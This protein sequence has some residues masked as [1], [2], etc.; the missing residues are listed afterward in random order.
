MVSHLDFERLREAVSGHAAAFRITTRLQPAGGPGA[1]V[2]PPT[3]MGGV[4]AWERRRIGNESV[5]TVL[6]D[7]AQSQANRM[8]QAL[9]EAVRA[10]TLQLPL[11]QVDF[12]SRFPDIGTITTLDAP[13]RIADAIF[14]DS[15]IGD[16][17]FR[18]SDIGQAFEAANFRNATALLQYCPHALVFGVWDST[19]SKGGSGNKFQRAITSEIIGINAEKG[20]QS[21]SRIDPLS[22]TRAAEVF[23]DSTGDWTRTES[24]AQR[25]KS[26][27]PVTAR[28]SEFL[29]G[30]IPP[31]FRRYNPTSNKAP[32]RT[33]YEE[34]RVGDVL[35]GGV[36]IDY[37][38][39]TTVLSIPALR[40]LRFPVRG[41]ENAERNNAAR[42]LLTALAL[43][44]FT[45]CRDAG[46]DLRSRCLLVVEEVASIELIDNDGSI[47]SFSLNSEQAQSLFESAVRNVRDTGLPWETAPINLT[48]QPRLFDLVA[49]SRAAVALDED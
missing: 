48:P 15:L 39:Q 17:K 38:I 40:R 11:L 6:L 21:S 5:I 23:K 34:I 45:L 33:M 30:N 41:E 32:L 3:H 1:K 9:L 7:S 26:G 47:T 36:T 14:R 10:Q 42:T 19:G 28:P 29:H 46:Y 8:E 27:A 16:L 25:T 24:E 44:A 2:F 43:N 31:D 35:A 20:V 37:A 18:D 4:Y 22:I 49:A 12:G 13:H